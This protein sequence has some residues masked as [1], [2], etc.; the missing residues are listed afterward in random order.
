MVK[1]NF[2]HNKTNVLCCTTDTTTI[3]YHT[4]YTDTRSAL[5]QS[6]LAQCLFALDG[7]VI[8]TA[9]ERAK[10]KKKKT[11]GKL[12]HKISPPYAKHSDTKTYTKGLPMN[13][14]DTG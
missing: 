2:V 5:H 12:Y 7:K 14:C 1:K 9:K 13:Q 11:T 6:E 10:E 4:W 8:K 3:A